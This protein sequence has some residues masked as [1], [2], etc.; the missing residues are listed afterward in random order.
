MTQ[1]EVISPRPVSKRGP[2]SRIHSH[3][4]AFSAACRMFLVDLLHCSPFT[5]SS[6]TG[7]CSEWP[8]KPL[9]PTLTGAQRALQTFLQHSVTRPSYLALLHL[10]VSSIWSS[11]T[12]RTT[13]F[14]DCEVYTM[15]GWTGVVA[16]FS[17]NLS[18]LPR[19]TWSCQSSVVARSP[20][21]ELG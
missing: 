18:C 10:L 3:R 9:H 5:P 17:G 12:S 1:T 11:G 20:P 21:E 8:A 13:C 4:E 19:S 6:L 15:S 14:V 7:H 16:M 2:A